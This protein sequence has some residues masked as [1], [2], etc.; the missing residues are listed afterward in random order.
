MGSLSTT[1]DEFLVFGPQCLAFDRTAA[2]E[3]RAHLVGN[4]SMSWALETLRGLASYWTE[5]ES[6]IP[7]LKESHGEEAMGD[8][9]HWLSTGEFGVVKFPLPNILLT[10]LVVILHLA[11]YQQLRNSSKISRHTK[12]TLGLCTGLLSAAAVSCSD[13]DKQLQQNGATV[14]RLAMVLGAVVDGNDVSL[15]PEMRAKSY[16]VAWTSSGMKADL[17]RMLE[18][19]PEV[20]SFSLP[21]SYYTISGFED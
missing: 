15:G 18:V 19:F 2:N 10:P 12:E 9:N 17:N 13:D 7:G 20:C 1:Q 8:L 14:V 11:Q 6:T 16:S 3:L 4:K 5:L 21:F